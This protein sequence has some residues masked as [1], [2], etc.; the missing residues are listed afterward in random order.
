MGELAAVGE[1]RH[2]AFISIHAT[3]KLIVFQIRIQ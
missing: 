1:S 3:S 2:E